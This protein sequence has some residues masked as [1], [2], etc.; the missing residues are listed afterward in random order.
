MPSIVSSPQRP[1]SAFRDLTNTPCRIGHPPSSDPKISS[2]DK[3]ASPSHD[4][5]DEEDE[6]DN[7]ASIGR[8]LVLW[9]LFDAYPSAI[10]RTSD[11]PGGKSPI[12]IALAAG[13]Y[14]AADFLQKQLREVHYE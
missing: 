7:D 4:F 8:P 6:E 12:D 1:P 2:P 10:Y 3:A 9:L 14:D 13:H 5:Y 11:G